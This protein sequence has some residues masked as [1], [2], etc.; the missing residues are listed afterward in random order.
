MAENPMWNLVSS[1]LCRAE[2]RPHPSP[3]HFL[4]DD[5]AKRYSACGISVASILRHLS[6]PMKSIAVIYSMDHL[7]PGSLVLSGVWP[8]VIPLH[9]VNI[10]I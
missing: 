8:I 9:E 4:G 3:C 2:F 1:Y 5:S 10:S 7:V 6:L